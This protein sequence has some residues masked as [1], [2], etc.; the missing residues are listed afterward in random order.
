MDFRWVNR[1]DYLTD[2]QM[3][4][5]T[6]ILMVNLTEIRLDYQTEMKK[7]CLLTVRPMDC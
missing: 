6:E 2:F 5:L 3:G 7:G 1:K 4:N